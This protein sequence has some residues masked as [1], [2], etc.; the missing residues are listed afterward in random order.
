MRLFRILFCL[1]CIQ[2]FAEEVYVL[3]TYTVTATQIEEPEL[4]VPFSVSQ[5]DAGQ[6]QTA[7]TQLSLDESLQTVP[8]VFVLNPYNFAQ[9]SRIAIRGF[10]AR[11]NFG[12]RGIRLLVDGIPATTPDGQGSVDGLDLGSAES[13]QVIRGPASALY[14]AASGGVILIETERG[15]ETPFMETRWTV[16]DYGLVQGQLKAGGQVGKLNYLMSATTLDYEGYRAN[17]DTENERINV[18]FVYELSEASSLSALINLIDFALQ[19]DPGGLTEAEARADP[20]QARDRNLQYESG[21][22]VQQEQFGLIYKRRLNDSHAFELKSYYTHRDF[23]NK[24]PFLGGGQVAFE[25]DFFGGGALYRFTGDRFKLAAG[26][27]YDLQDDARENYDNL[28]GI[29]GPLS[30]QQNERIESLGLFVSSSYVLTDALTLSTAL[31]QDALEFRVDDSFLG[32]GDDSGERSFTETSPMAGIIWEVAPAFAVF[33]N[34]ATSFETPTSTELANPIGGGF[35]PNVGPQTATNFELGVK[36]LGEF[37]SRRLRYELTAF[38]ID[39]QDALVPF[40]LLSSPGR[41]FYRNAGESS[42]RGIEAALQF[43]LVE[44]L[45]ADLSY[46]WSDF[47]YDRF[48]TPSGDFS[49]NRLPGIPEHFGNLQIN[50]RNDAGV[51]LKWNTRF[52]GSLYADDANAETIEAYSVSDLRFGIERTFGA[53]TFEPFMGINNI[54]DQVYN[55][56]IRINAFGGRYYEPA[57]E[58]NL[59]GGLRV[60]YA[61][62]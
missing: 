57:P 53:W 6:L 9:D 13:M 34:A 50:Y 58:R 3:P 38:Q 23:A 45:S 19:N 18:K 10:G 42:R 55:A 60:R 39:I 29:L 43:E 25:R 62:D 20:R 7:S 36:G 8:G 12:I 51:F 61:F 16:G 35:N 52:T 31:R 30:L 41:D 40:E 14:G 17:N 56:N 4:S 21:E 33:A 54:F 11:A 28:N 32:D 47:T 22:S 15:P 5:I 1:A 27:D 24:L 44:H 46:T 2:G 26:I 48:N 37:A 49:G 59:Y